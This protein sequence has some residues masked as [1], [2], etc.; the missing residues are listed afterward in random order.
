[1]VLVP[2]HAEPMGHSLQ[3]VRFVVDVPPEV[4]QPAPHTAQLAAWFAL[5]MS[6]APHSKQPPLSER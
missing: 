1:M 4:N 3:A 5:H 6:S 2:S